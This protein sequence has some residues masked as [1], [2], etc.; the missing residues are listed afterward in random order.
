M[1]HSRTICIA[2]LALW[3]VLPMQA[4]MLKLIIPDKALQQGVM[5]INHGQ[6]EQA[7]FDKQGCWTYDKGTY[8]RPTDIM[9]MIGTSGMYPAVIQSGRKQTVT[10]TAKKGKT[11][12]DYAGDN[13]E[14]ARFYQLYTALGPEKNERSGSDFSDMDIE[15]F[16][17]AA[18]KVKRETITYHEAFARLD[19][20]HAETVK[21]ANRVRESVMREIYLKMT[22]MRYLACRLEL[23]ADQAWSEKRDIRADRDYGKLIAQID[24]NDPDGLDPLFGLPQTFIDYHLSTSKDAE[25]LTDYG[26]DY[27]HVVRQHV[28][29][30]KVKN[31]LL[32]NLAS[33]LFAASTEMTGKSFDT[34][35]FWD[36]FVKEAD[37][38][39]VAKLQYIVDSRKNAIAGAKCPDVTFSDI[40]GN[41]HKLSDYFGTYIYIDIWATWCGPCCAE[42]PYIEKWV[43]HYKDNPK[44]KFLSISIDTNLNAWKKKVEKDKPQWLQ[45][46]CNKEENKTL[47]EQWGVVGIPRFIIINPDGTICRPDAFRPSDPQFQTRMDAIINGSAS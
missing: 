8:E 19:R 17:V 5:L 34:S 32:D 33:N 10:V 24:P 20:K 31:A 21:A 25:N 1:K 35:T 15:E 45:F 18:E 3:N 9:L 37:P 29:D 30:P 16:R 14:N 46:N 39:T 38:N 27:I 41:R 28:T 2:L 40:E 42:I 43:A 13:V 26:L 6:F 12:V 22:K 44:I 47:T 23:T 4:Q 7:A 36:A 11:Q